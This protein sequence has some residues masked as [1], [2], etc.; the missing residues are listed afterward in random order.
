MSISE[1]AKDYHDLFSRFFIENCNI[2]MEE[3]TEE[4]KNTL[5]DLDS[6][7]VFENLEDLIT[8]LL[9]FKK[10]LI[11][12]DPEELALRLINFEN[13]IQRLESEVRGHI[14]LQNQLKIIIENNQSKI[15]E[16]EKLNS[17]Q[18]KQ[19]I[20]QDVI[21]K[22]KD[23]KL[24]E[25]LKTLPKKNNVLNSETKT[26]NDKQFASHLNKNNS[27]QDSIFVKAKNFV[28]SHK[29]TKSDA[30]LISTAHNKKQTIKSVRFEYVPSKNNKNSTSPG[31]INFYKTTDGSQK[32]LKST[33]PTKKTKALQM[34]RNS[35]TPYY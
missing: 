33:K 15:Q 27:S 14:A 2:E 22:E 6:D 8:E 26:M 32:S 1:K 19:I 23:N 13:I 3:I 31:Q 7:E 10:K 29:R 28:I 34:R 21:I 12:S 9:N 17:E 18:S 24:R 35:D 30:K 25:I 11:R 16:L 5:K 20:D 4:E